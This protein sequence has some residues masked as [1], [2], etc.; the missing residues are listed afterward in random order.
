M[1]TFLWMTSDI[2]EIF[3]KKNRLHTELDNVESTC[4]VSADPALRYLTVFKKGDVFWG[5]GF[6]YKKIICNFQ[7]PS[8]P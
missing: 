2:I 1:C 5:A 6:T 8:Q 7:I 3:K 4:L